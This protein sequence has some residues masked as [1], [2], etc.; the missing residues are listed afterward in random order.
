MKLPRLNRFAAVALLAVS[1]P[2]APTAPAAAQWQGSARLAGTVLDHRGEPLPGATVTVHLTDDATAG[3][4]PVATGDDGAWSVAGLSPGPWGVRI[5]ARGY[6]PAIG[7]MTAGA[8]TQPVTVELRPL[9][10]V[11]PAFPEGNPRQFAAQALALA[12]LLLAQ[13]DVPEA[14][15]EHL[16]AL[17]GLSEPAERAEV[18]RHLAR[19]HHLEGDTELAVLALRHSLVLDPGSELG[20]QLYLG[21]APDGTAW[22]D[23]LDARGPD[24]VAVDLDPLP[25]LAPAG[26]APGPPPKIEPLAPEA[27]RTGAFT[28]RLPGR[29]PESSPK[30]VAERLEVSARDLTR[31]GALAY[32]A[33]DESLELM[34]PDAYRAP[35]RADDGWGAIV[36]VS[37][38]PRGFPPGPP[39]DELLELLARHRLIWVGANGSGNQRGIADRLGLALDAA[40]A[41]ASLYDLDPGRIVVAGY[42]GGGRIA[43]MLA[44]LWPDIFAG[45]LF[46]RGADF[47]RPLPIPDRPGLQW[48]GAF[49]E[50]PR[51]LRGTLEDDRR[52]VVLTGEHDFNRVQSREVAEAYQDDGYSH[53][54]YLEIPGAT[55]YTPLG[56]DDLDR[57]LAALVTPATPE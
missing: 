24:A 12:D 18:L 28:V 38:T 41:V 5:Q 15:R 47:Y 11:P 48:P 52:F 13:G 40:H 16:R 39:K 19:T 7:R 43:S 51:S 17:R 37:P 29:S 14:R 54:T 50:P 44:N 33:S 10:E 21:V 46:V 22:L 3:P 56:A 9:T 30:A 1:L 53:V 4:E 23:D 35:H 55:H 8:R 27:G 49:P 42:S 57:A 6:F 45:G 34:V 31:G 25:G 26:P 2:V 32:S 20:R 36:W